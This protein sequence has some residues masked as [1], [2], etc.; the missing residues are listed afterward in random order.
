M[1]SY[2]ASNFSTY[3]N[4]RVATAYLE[5]G[6]VSSTHHI[7]THSPQYQNDPNQ[8]ITSYLSFNTAKVYTQ[9]HN[10]LC[11]NILV[12]YNIFSIISSYFYI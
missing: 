1:Y 4:S 9:Y 8:D 5:D 10:I 12:Y 6:G 3:Y 11:Y 7:A 2:T